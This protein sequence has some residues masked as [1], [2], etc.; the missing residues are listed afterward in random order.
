MFL[1][2]SR[3]EAN[4]AA[5]GGVAGRR[6]ADWHVSSAIEES[7]RTGDLDLVHVYEIEKSGHDFLLRTSEVPV[8]TG[9]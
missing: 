6:M 5:G 7:P 2:Q 9:V 3:I 1:S 8:F 4:K